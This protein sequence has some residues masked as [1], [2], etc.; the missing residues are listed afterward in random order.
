MSARKIIEVTGSLAVGGAER[1]AVEVAVGIQGLGFASEVVCAGKVE[2]PQ[3]AY[4]RGLRAEIEG[5]GVPVSYVVYP[6]FFDHAARRRFRAYL[7]ARGADLVH[8][9]NRPQDWQTVALCKLSGIPVLYTVHLTYAPGSKKAQAIYVACG[10]A[11]PKV[12]CCS[13]AVARYVAEYEHVPEENIVVLYNG[14]RTDVYVP[15]TAEERR[16]KRAEL[17]WADDELVFFAAAR[18]SDQKGH[19]FLIDGFSRLATSKKTKLVIAGEGPRKADLEAQIERLGLTGRVSLLGARRDVPSLLGAADAYASASL[20][21]GHPL[22]LLEAMATELPVVAPRLPTIE[23]IAMDDAPLLYGPPKDG[24]PTSHD[25]ADVARGLTEA[26]ARLD[27]LRA[28]VKRARPAI[29]ERYSLDAMNR[30][31]ARLYDELL[32][33]SRPSVLGRSFGRLFA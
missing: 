12:A 14:I 31:H 4:E 33:H 16:A 13:K 10:R 24:A 27:E 25:P 22:S 11:V 30:N 28:K 3:T 29:A 18:L 1:V 20:Q 7:E 17:G 19:S 15:V 9:H 32:Q 5:R 6:S 2:E 21:E 26:I 23:E 8:V